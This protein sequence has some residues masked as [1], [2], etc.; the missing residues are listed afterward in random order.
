MIHISKNDKQRAGMQSPP[1]TVEVKSRA[2]S[3]PKP[4]ATLTAASTISRA[5]DV[6]KRSTDPDATLLLVE[7][8]DRL[9]VYVGLENFAASPERA[10]MDSV[11]R[12][13]SESVLSLGGTFRWHADYVSQQMQSM[14]GQSM[15]GQL[16]GGTLAGPMSATQQ[17]H[18][19][20][21]QRRMYEYER[22]RAMQNAFPP[23]TM[24]KGYL[25]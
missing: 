2:A 21:T 3:T 14:A 22:A 20:E 1:E 8:A 19:L 9:A 23:I 12:E 4:Y 17:Q 7:L 15:A 11:V 10:E 16:L 13:A 6:A 25:P 18:I 24:P 5:L